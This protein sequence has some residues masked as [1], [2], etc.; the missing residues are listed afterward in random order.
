MKY[1]IV[2]F[3]LISTMET[4][5]S[6]SPEF[7]EFYKSSVWALADTWVLEA[8]QDNLSKLIDQQSVSVFEWAPSDSFSYDKDLEILTIIQKDETVT[9]EYA[10]DIASKQVTETMFAETII[11]SKLN[12]FNV[13]RAVKTKTFRDYVIKKVNELNLNV[14]VTVDFNSNEIFISKKRHVNNAAP[15]APRDMPKVCDYIT[16]KSAVKLLKSKILAS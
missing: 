2:L 8:I 7:Y 4:P 11:Y 13:G 9:T 14:F 16:T 6:L 3:T 12:T 10:Y 15:Y 1:I 5:S